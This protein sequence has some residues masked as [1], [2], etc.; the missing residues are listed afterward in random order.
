MWTISSSTNNKSNKM[1]VETPPNKNDSFLAT[2]APIGDENDSMY[3]TAGLYAR[4]K[5]ACNS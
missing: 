2:T 5:R 4:F 1:T 3:L